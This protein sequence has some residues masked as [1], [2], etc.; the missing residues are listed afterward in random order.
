[1]QSGR[2]KTGVRPSRQS[3]V[4]LFCFFSGNFC[5]NT[6]RR[7]D[8]CG[9]GTY[10]IPRHICPRRNHEAIPLHNCRTWEAVIY[11]LVFDS[12]FSF[13]FCVQQGDRVPFKHRE[14]KRGISL[15][16]F[17]WSE[18]E[19]SEVGRLYGYSQSTFTECFAG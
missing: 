4:V 1:M 2:P 13:F 8:I 11:W 18:T 5:D 17:C 19:H 16:C 10:W 9:M 12:I 14:K 6:S 15:D 3:E 7:L